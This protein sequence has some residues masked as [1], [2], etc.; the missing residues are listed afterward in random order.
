MAYAVDLNVVTGAPG[1]G[2]SA[3]LEAFLA[4]GSRYVALDIDWLAEPAGK[5]AGRSI[6]TDASTWP[7]YAALWFAVLRGIERNNQTPVFFTPNSP[8][9]FEC[10]G[11]PDW[12]SKVNWLLLECDKETRRQRLQQRPDWDDEMIKAA[13]E[14]AAQLRDLIAVAID[15]GSSNPKQTANKILQWLS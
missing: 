10:F 11:L 2:K 7:D 8:L 15:T 14:D 3:A 12:I 13:I 4:L 5:L 1:S 9:D 6:F